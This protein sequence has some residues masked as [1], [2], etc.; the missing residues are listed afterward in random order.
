M[1][2]QIT[3]NATPVEA[4]AEL[5]RWLD[6]G[7]YLQT[8]GTLC[9]RTETGEFAFCCLG[10]ASEIG[11]ALGLVEKETW[12]DN[13]G[14][15]DPQSGMVEDATLGVTLRKFFGMTQTG[16][17]TLDGKH[18]ELTNENDH[19]GKN[20]SQIAYLVR[21]AEFKRAPEP[22]VTFK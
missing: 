15:S 20:F 17:F 2:L 22:K 6:S 18:G 13:V 7:E 12:E 16:C 11:A 10:I 5:A 3:M 1:D 4:R 14:Y 8:T 19:N 9:R 21:N